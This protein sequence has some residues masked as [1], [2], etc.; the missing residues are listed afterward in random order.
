MTDAESNTFYVH[1]FGATVLVLPETHGGRIDLQSG[2]DAQLRHDPTR[3]KLKSMVIVDVP[4]EPFAL[5]QIEETQIL[6]PEFGWP[7]IARIGIC[8]LD[9]E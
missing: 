9:H 2:S 6:R 4:I 8:N 1:H 5:G 7:K 3:Q